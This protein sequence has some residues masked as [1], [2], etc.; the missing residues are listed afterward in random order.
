MPKA[1]V[2]AAS[3]GN[4]GA[5]V[6]YAA[7]KLNLPAH[8]FVPKIAGK[9]KID[10]IQATGARLTIVEGA[11][12]NALIEAE[13]FEKETGAMQV[14]AF[15]SIETTSGQGT[16]MREW[17]KQGLKADTI[18][19]AVGGGG[20]IAGAMAWLQ[21]ARKVIAV[22]PK[23]SCA[24]HSAMR[25]NQPVDVEVSGIASNALGAKRAGNICFELAK[26]QQIETLV[27]E[28]SD[29]AVAQKLLW[30]KFRQ[31][32]EPAAS[33]ALAAVTSGTYIPEKDEKIAILVCGANPPLNPFD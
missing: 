27:I 4:H 9:T 16:L 31:F 14:H 24:L 26:S 25:S 23:Q 1:G 32:V 15:D 5:A 11:Y 12:A 22:E 21:G 30:D 18:L 6:A 13:K 2:V 17:E 29:I 10:L 33:T 19:I 28:D 7:T 3:G 8:I 20:L